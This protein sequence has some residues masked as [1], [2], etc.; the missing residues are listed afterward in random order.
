[1]PRRVIDAVETRKHRRK[2]EE[3][4][5][6]MEDGRWK[7]EDGRWK[8]EDGRRQTKRGRC[9]TEDRDSEGNNMTMSVSSL[10]ICLQSLLIDFVALF[11]R[12]TLCTCT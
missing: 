5:K 6:K 3:G 4:R 11:V 8:M 9:S 7:M 1:M 2:K 10:G 12:F